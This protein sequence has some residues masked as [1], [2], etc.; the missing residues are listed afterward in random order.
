M[1]EEMVLLGVT[2]V[3]PVLFKSFTMSVL[4]RGSQGQACG[5]DCI[6]ETQNGLG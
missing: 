3:M 1:P 5:E 2:P 4:G 6:T